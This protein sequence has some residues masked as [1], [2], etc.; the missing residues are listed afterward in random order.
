[1]VAQRS[2]SAGLPAGWRLTLAVA[3]AGALAAIAW[4][5][6]DGLGYYTTAVVER[7]RLPEYWS[8]KPG[9]TRGHGLGVVGASLLV[10]M[11]VYSVR[12]RVRALSRLGPLRAWLH[13]HIFCGIVGT[14]LVVL[15]SSFKV[16]GLVAL[17]F[18]SMIVV[19][20][21]GVLGRYLY[22]QIPRTRA[23]DELTLEEARQASDELAERAERALGIDRAV[24]ERLDAEARAGAAA[25]LPL[26]ILLLRLPFGGL[27]LRWRLRRLLAKLPAPRGGDLAELAAALRQRAVLERRLALWHRLHDL[28]HYWHVFHKPFA[29]VMY[30][31]LI[32][33]VVV[34]VLTGYAWGG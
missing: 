34:V 3:Y 33:H 10:L 6:W 12:K 2:P 11:L 27:A 29:A 1:M 7:P 14:L 28:F 16:R 30:L 18:W 23:G 9:G 5:A 26:P 20:V 8:L 15:H 13:F 31:F 25:A 17:S 32:L 24:L 4:L 21:S 22:L 19:A